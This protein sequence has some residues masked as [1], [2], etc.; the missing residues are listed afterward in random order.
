MAKTRTKSWNACPSHLRNPEGVG[1]DGKALLNQIYTAQ[2]RYRVPVLQ[3]PRDYF[4]VDES[5]IASV[6]L[7]PISE[8][9]RE[10]WEELVSAGYLERRDDKIRLTPKGTKELPGLIN[11]SPSSKDLSGPK[12]RWSRRVTATGVRDTREEIRQQRERLRITR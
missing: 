11:M 4:G 7:T 8:R 9:T 1:S 3:D 5:Q 2:V 6:R 12:D 10:G